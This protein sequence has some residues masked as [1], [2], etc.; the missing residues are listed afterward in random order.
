MKILKVALLALSTVCVSTS[1]LAGHHAGSKGYA[2]AEDGKTLAVMS[3]LAKPGAI[4]SYSLSRS[5]SAIAYRPVTGDLLGLVMEL[6]ILLMLNREN[7]LAMAQNLWAML[8]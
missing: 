3:D 1:V 6:F 7:Y 8:L 4:T 2:L 5:L